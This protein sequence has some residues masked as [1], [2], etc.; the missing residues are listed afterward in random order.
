MAALTGYLFVACLDDKAPTRLLAGWRGWAVAG[1]ALGATL[2]IYQPGR[3][4]PVFFVSLVAYLGLFDR[5]RLA[6]HWRGIALFFA[7]ALVVFCP[8]GVYLLGHTEDRV[9]QV[10]QPIVA[11][12]DGDPGPMLRNGLRAF[13]MFT[14]I[15][16]PHWRQFVADTPVF[17]PLG[18]V[19]FYA[20]VLI[21]LWRAR[22][23]PYAFSLIWLPIMLSPAAITEG[24]PNF[25][26]SIAVLATV[27]VFPALAMDRALDW[28]RGRDRRWAWACVAAWVAL[29]GY[30]GWRAYDG[31]F[32]RWT[33][34][35]DARFAY[36]ATII[37]AGLY[38]DEADALDSVVLSGLLPADLDPALVDSAMR[39]TD[40]V[41]RWCDVRQALLYPGG[42]TSHVI[43]PDYFPIDPLLF[44][45]YMR[46]PAAAHERRLADGTRVFAVYPLADAGL[47]A[48]RTDAAAAPVGWSTAAAFPDGMP[49]DLAPLS[50]P[51]AFGGRVEALGYEVLGG[52]KATPG[53]AVT[54]V[55]YWR[56]LAPASAKAIT[57]LHVLSPGGTVVAGHDGFGAPPNRWLSG[58]VVVQLHRFALPA[59][60]GSGV[61]PVEIGWYERDTGLRWTVAAGGGEVD[62]LL[63]GPLWVVD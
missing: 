46:A 38:L 19:L 61:Y 37:E 30:N 17:E 47:R 24:A 31:Y 26:R 63:I 62:R 18:G 16:D 57:F 11:L 35:P 49:A 39:R 9:A 10:N 2:Y 27:Y 59:E 13:G 48:H 54:L 4:V 15:G 21:S 29:L 25:L 52:R 58:D 7:V 55:T 50:W 42:G 32:R 8:L 45:R 1:L 36:N 20:G 40:M 12:L 44:E 34:H 41:P 3:V 60:L 51:V 53:D 28:L 23:L 22:H 56:A 5:P 14:A 6:R 43:E 33:N